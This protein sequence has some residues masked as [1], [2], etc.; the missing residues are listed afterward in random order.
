M[1]NKLI[2]GLAVVLAVGATVYKLALAE[3]QRAA[4]NPAPK[5]ESTIVMDKPTVIDLAGGRY[6][7]VTVGI[8]VPPK[9]EEAFAESDVVRDVITRD[10][11]GLDPQEL[12]VRERRER[13]KLRMAR[14]VR[15]Q[16]DVQV[17]RVLLTDF[18]IR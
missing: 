17:G 14:D 6:A 4:A 15:A 3:P 16:T 18:T 11:T 1:I 12:L 8:E 13:L 10:L 5:A 7:R 9:Y 2:L